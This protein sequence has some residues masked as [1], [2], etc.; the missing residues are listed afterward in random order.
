[1]ARPR[2][3]TVDFFPHYCNH[4][5]TIFILE[6]RFGITGY[7]FWWKLLEELG[8]HEGHYL[9]LKDENELEFLG[10]KTRVSGAET[11]SMLD[12][13]SK[14]G[15]IDPKLWENRIVWCQKFVDNLKEVYLKRTVSVPEKPVSV[16]D[17]PI[18]GTDNP[19]SRVDESKL[20]SVKEKSFTPKIK[21]MEEEYTLEELSYETVD[22]PKGKSK[23]GSK[24]MA[25]LARKF[26]EVAG[27][28]I[29]QTFDASEWAKPLGAIYKRFNKDPDKTMKFFEGAGKWYTDKGLTFTPHTLEKNFTMLNDKWLKQTNDFR[30]N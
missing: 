17:N 29:G 13:A 26:A 27:I 24:T 4:G 8:K 30:F 6:Q 16:P 5:K 20:H 15:A 21:L 11:I 25:I 14:L 19:Q 10:A 7:A 3:Q 9:D 1:M 22:A 28:E 12:L 18:S 2:K 23:Y